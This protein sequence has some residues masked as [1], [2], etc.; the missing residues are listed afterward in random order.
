MLKSADKCNSNGVS[1]YIG[2]PLLCGSFIFPT[3]A[4][5][6]RLPLTI[7]PSRFDATVLVKKGI[8]Y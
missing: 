8:S 4:F 5:C 3:K 2:S 6:S 1:N 7:C